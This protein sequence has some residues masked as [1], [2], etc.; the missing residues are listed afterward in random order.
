MTD[1][2][3][4][5]QEF[6]QWYADIVLK[7]DL[8]DHTDVSGCSIIKPYSF[9]IWEKIKQYL[10]EEFKKR[11]VKNAYFPS[12]ISEDLL[13]KESDHIE[14]F[15]PE[16]AWVTHGGNTK[17]GKRLAIR[18]TSET[19][20]CKAYSNW[21]RSH[22]DLP[23]KINQWVNVVRWEFKHPTPFL[24]G[25]EFLWQ[26]GHTVFANKEEAEKEV[27]DILKLYKE[28]YEKLMAIPVIEG[29]KS[30]KEKFAGANYSLSL[31]AVM[32]DGKAIQGCTSHYL[33]TSFAESFDIKYLDEN[34]ENKYVHQNSWGLS[35]R[36]IGTIIAVHGDDN[37]L[38]LPPKLAPIQAVVVPIVFSKKPKVSKKINEY[39][40]KISKENN[41]E[42]DDR[43][44]SPGFKFNYWEL[45][46]VPVRIEVGPRDMDKGV[47]TLVRRDTGEKNQVKQENVSKKVKELLQQ[48]Q[49]DMLSKQR[50]KLK[51]KIV[52]VNNMEELK[53]AI[54]QGKIA[55]APWQGLPSQEEKIK[56]ETGAK[57]LN[58][59]L[60]QTG[61][62]FMTGKQN[63]PLTHFGKTI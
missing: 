8:I 19:V 39:T 58:T 30:E 53:K 15:A 55:R 13:Q 48:I 33:G 4:K 60:K 42:L 16:V 57:S 27:H 22:R 45:R 12:L 26:E 9:E 37:G 3:P 24:R 29:K 52:D 41:W 18:P 35:T 59:S 2:L 47:A 51:Q 50:K 28:V 63:Q 34:G 49:K 40:K 25:R 23:L 21:I 11:G 1:K 62:C 20:I 5:K 10:D 44:Q 7:A 17:L 61:K 6:S 54:N 43:D 38:V 32:E 46:G 56:E 31:E 36:T 14:G